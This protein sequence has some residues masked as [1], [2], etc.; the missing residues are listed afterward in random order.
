LHTEPSQ[1][2]TDFGGREPAQ[3]L[4]HRRALYIDVFQPVIGHQG[5]EVSQVADWSLLEKMDT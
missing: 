2:F 5:F 3:P 1:A 4:G